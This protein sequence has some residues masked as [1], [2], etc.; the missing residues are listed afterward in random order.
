MREL[1][2]CLIVTLLFC[3][4]WACNTKNS[5]EKLTP[6]TKQSELA[7]LMRIMETHGD[8]VRVA[9]RNEQA[10]P[11]RP[12]GIDLL[13]SAKATPDMHI[14]QGTFPVFVQQYLQGI[15]AL[16]AASSLNR[17]EA[18]NA[19]V[20][21]CSNCHIVNCPGPLMKIDKMFINLQ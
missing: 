17:E 21:S 1:K 3:G 12:E 4:L 15:D 19:V 5:S 8:E 6:D 20:Q 13:L 10:L 11:S 18:Y 9:L 7:A 16:Y 2:L 14:D